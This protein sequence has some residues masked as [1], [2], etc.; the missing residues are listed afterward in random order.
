[1]DKQTQINLIAG[2]IMDEFRKHNS[3]MPD[4]WHLIAAS[5]IRSQWSEFDKDVL[6]NTFGNYCAING[7]KLTD[8]NKVG[9]ATIDFFKS[10]YYIKSLT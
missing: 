10:D 4:E 9:Q 5:K 3:Q 7:V 2:R 1:M 8:S 6:L